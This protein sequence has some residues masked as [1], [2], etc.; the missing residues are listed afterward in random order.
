M[1]VSESLHLG[2]SAKYFSATEVETQASALTSLADDLPDGALKTQIEAIIATLTALA[3]SLAS[4]E[5]L[6]GRKVKRATP[7]KCFL[8]C[9]SFI[10]YII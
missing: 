2:N 10:I 8:Y 1:F 7:G 3:S 6:T 9:I 4:L 5:A